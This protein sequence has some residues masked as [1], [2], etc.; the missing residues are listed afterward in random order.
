M[1]PAIS[2]LIVSRTTTSQEHDRTY[3]SET[4]P[5]L[6]SFDGLERL[7][8]FAVGLDVAINTAQG[9]TVTDLETRSQLYRALTRS[10]MLAVV[11]NE[12][13]RGGWLEFLGTV[14]LERG[15]AFDRDAERRRM[16]NDAVEALVAQRL[17]LIDAAL[18]EVRAGSC[19]GES[20]D[21]WWAL[22][23]DHA[24]RAQVNVTRKSFKMNGKEREL[25]QQRVAKQASSVEDVAPVVEEVVKAWANEKKE[26]HAAIESEALQVHSAS[27]PARHGGE[28]RRGDA[29]WLREPPTSDASCHHPSPAF[30]L[31][32]QVTAEQEVELQKRLWDVQAP[33]AGVHSSDRSGSASSVVQQWKKENAILAI[34]AAETGLSQKARDQL[35]KSLGSP[36]PNVKKN[37]AIEMRK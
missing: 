1:S 10:H 34:L 30:A 29:L 28:L 7:I 19:S 26:L 8:I 12:V 27:E 33:A 5:P 6:G 36:N 23:S 20:L 13:V 32:V 25:L 31:R 3:L 18:K 11:I 35:K 21:V 2:R 14:K 15:V 16:N 22:T 24:L 9:S 37:A 4:A 17:K